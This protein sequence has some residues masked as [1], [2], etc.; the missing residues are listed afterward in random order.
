MAT[1]TQFVD[2]TYQDGRIRDA[3]LKSRSNLIYF[4]KQGL[5][6][7]VGDVHQA[8]RV[9]KGAWVLLV[10]LRVVKKSAANTT[11]HLGYGSDVNYWGNALPLD[12]P[13]VV[14]SVAIDTEEG[15]IQIFNDR[16]PLSKAP[17]YFAD[18]DTIDIKATIDKADVNITTGELEVNVLYWDT[19][20]KI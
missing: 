11:V 15:N 12:S 3:V 8:V 14:P 5:D 6:A 7:G 19:Q 18:D 2:G 13:G 17:V 1:K 16:S 9:P 20:I 4:E 10:F